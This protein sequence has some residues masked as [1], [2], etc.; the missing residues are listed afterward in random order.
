MPFF[1][2]AESVSTTPVTIFDYETAGGRILAF[3]AKCTTADCKLRLFGAIPNA[4]ADEVILTA[5]DDWF[6]F[7]TVGTGI[8]KIVAVTASGTS[9]LTLETKGI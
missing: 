1:N 3:R 5:G 7:F 4:A 8:T 2:Y 9:A 6:E